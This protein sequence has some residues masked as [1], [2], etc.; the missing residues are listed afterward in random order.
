ML[1]VSLCHQHFVWYCLYSPWRINAWVSNG[2]IHPSEHDFLP[3]CS[4]FF[5]F[6]LPS[7]RG[8]KNSVLLLNIFSE[9]RLVHCAWQCSFKVI[10]KLWRAFLATDVSRIECITLDMF[11]Q[12]SWPAGPSA[13]GACCVALICVLVI[14]HHT[15]ALSCLHVG[16]GVTS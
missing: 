1:A 13:Q 12:C 14:K 4:N 10:T 8:K 6:V 15:C 5:P 16:D 9:V 7:Q 2:K 11:T 3:G